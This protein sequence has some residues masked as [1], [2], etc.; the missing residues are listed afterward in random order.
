MPEF[1]SE[2]DDL[3]ARRD[4]AVWVRQSREAQGLPPKVENPAVLA[5]VAHMLRSKDSR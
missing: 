5:R 2:K 4:V 1:V 3:P